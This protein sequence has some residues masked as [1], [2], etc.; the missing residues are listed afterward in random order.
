MPHNGNGWRPTRVT[1]FIQPIGTSTGP[2]LVDT[3]AGEGYLKALGNPEGPHALACEFVGSMLADWLGLSTLDFALVDVTEDDEI[4]FSKSG[5]ALPGP[6]F[7]SRS[8]KFG[9]PWGGDAKYLTLVINPQ[10]ISGLIVMD[11]WTLNY[12]RYSPDGERRN[13]EN[14]FLIQCSTSAEVKLVAMDFTHA[15]RH[16]GDLNRRL[17]N[18]DRRRDEKVYGRFPEFISFLNREQVRHYSLRLGQFRREIADEFIRMVPPEWEVDRDGRS[19][20]ARQITDRAGFLA[21]NIESILWP[22]QVLGFEGGT[23]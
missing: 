3:D 14:V 8:E 15:F 21:E 12:D 16:G 11:T 5:R 2:A 10:E 9:N 1:R 18:I 4:P 6:A 13:Y 19:A 7:I 23:E 17:D 22:Q 20:W